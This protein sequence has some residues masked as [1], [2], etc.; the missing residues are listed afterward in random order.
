MLQGIN[1]CKDQAYEQS[2]EYTWQ[3]VQLHI[4]DTPHLLKHISNIMST[5]CKFK[6]FVNLDFVQTHFDPTRSRRYTYYYQYYCMHPNKQ[7]LY[8]PHKQSKSVPPL[9]G[10]NRQHPI[11]GQTQ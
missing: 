4:C 5:L 1:H 3:T 8:L 10:Q 11:S 2:V 7:N 9:L 6:Q